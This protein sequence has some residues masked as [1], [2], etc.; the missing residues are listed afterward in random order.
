[1]RYFTLFMII[2]LSASPLFSQTRDTRFVAVQSEDVKESS[3]NFARN[4]GSLSMGDS[5][6]LARDDG[7]W[8]QISTQS[9][10]GWVRSSSLTTRRV[11]P[12][13]ASTATAAEIALA[14]KG[15]S[16]DIEIEY[17]RT[18]LN[19]SMV[20]S[21]ERIAISPQELLNFIREGHLSR[22]E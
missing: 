20:D 8:A 4:L 17:R 3:S 5:V 16:P 14:G 2:I 13:G 1:M 11:L 9:L 21:M 10:N 22:G 19:Y 7:R 15:F 18:G 12:A 6:N